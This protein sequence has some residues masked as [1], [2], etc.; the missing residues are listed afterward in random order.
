VLASPRTA[1]SGRIRRIRRSIG[2]QADNRSLRSP[3]GE[4]VVFS[5]ILPHRARNPASG[6]IR[7]GRDESVRV[8]AAGVRVRLEGV[9]AHSRLACPSY[10][11][12]IFNRAQ[13]TCGALSH[14]RG[15]RSFWRSRPSGRLRRSTSNGT[16]SAILSRGPR[17]SPATPTP[18]WRR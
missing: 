12:P 14:R 8:D 11:A 3:T 5:A 17:S 4:S 15:R 9:D 10:V 1:N 18:I 7:L 2:A 16:S 6:H 13:P